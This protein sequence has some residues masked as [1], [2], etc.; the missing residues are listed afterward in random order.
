MEE[1]K[2]FSEMGKLYAEN[3]GL[4]MEAENYFINDW[5]NLMETIR[6]RIQNICEVIWYGKERG[7]WRVLVIRKNKLTLGLH[8]DARENEGIMFFDLGRYPG[9]PGDIMPKIGEKIGFTMYKNNW[10]YE[11]EL[12]EDDL[13]KKC[14]TVVKKFV[15]EASKIKKSSKSKK[16]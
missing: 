12:A 2:R 1:F 7:K 6:K 13:A 4:I 16:K 9:V 15:S 5:E 3:Y 14:E 10:V 8:L 11:I